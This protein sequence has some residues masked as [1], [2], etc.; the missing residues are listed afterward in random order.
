MLPRTV[1]IVTLVCQMEQMNLKNIGKK[2]GVLFNPG[3]DECWQHFLHNALAIEIF[4]K[5]S[6]V[7]ITNFFH[8]V[9]L[10]MQEK[11]FAILVSD[12][13]NIPFDLL[14]KQA[15]Q[16]KKKQFCKYH[17]LF[18]PGNLFYARKIFLPIY[19]VTGSTLHLTFI[20]NKQINS[21]KQ[22]C[23]YHKLFSPGNPFYARKTFC[24]FS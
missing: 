15:D 18:S 11:L 23:K 8:L 16:F 4:F 22:F 9:T 12:W 6:F 19:L 13:V 7:I 10:F 3:N 17:K 1:F 24:H 21:K 5:K 2:L 20:K 14:T